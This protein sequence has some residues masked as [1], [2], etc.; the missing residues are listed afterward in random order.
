MS[1]LS[2][3]SPILIVAALE[4][5]IAPLVRKRLPGVE[6]LVTGEGRSNAERALRSRLTEGRYKA[7]ICTGFAGALSPQ[8]RIGDLIIDKSR[9]RGTELPSTA[10]PFKT[11]FG[12]VI[13]VDEIVGAVGKR[14]LAA[15]FND[16]EIACV[17]MESAA[18]AKVCDE[19]QMPLLLVR[20]ISDLSDEDL[21]IDFNA[22]RD[23][24]GRVSNR[25]VLQ[26]VTRKP[27]AIPGLLELNRRARLG[28]ANLAEFITEW[29]TG[30]KNAT[31]PGD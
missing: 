7:V 12:T 25:K 9:W 22:C 8:L 17:D 5:E 28:A 3:K 14:Q 15:T 23:K 16:G 4:R 1:D 24:S 20:V 31:I 11:H 18:V 21:P 2:K 10:T 6:F 19:F 27:Q 26:A 13:T 30:E 29:L